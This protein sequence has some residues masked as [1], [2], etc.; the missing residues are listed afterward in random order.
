MMIMPAI[1]CDV[2]ILST[3]IAIVVFDDTSMPTALTKNSEVAAA[4]YGIASATPTV[5]VIDKLGAAVAVPAKTFIT[6]TDTTAELA[7]TMYPAF[8][9][10]LDPGAQA[11][12]PPTTNTFD[13]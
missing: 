10:I 12:V 13:V 1:L 5:E 11:G 9:R 4:M 7:A 8:N 2:A 3:P 6:P